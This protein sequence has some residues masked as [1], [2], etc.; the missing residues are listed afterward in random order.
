L[1]R[2]SRIRM[3]LAALQGLFR[4]PSLRTCRCRARRVR[5]R[6]ECRLRQQQ[7]NTPNV[8]FDACFQTTVEHIPPHPY[9]RARTLVLARSH[10][11]PVNVRRPF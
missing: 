8:Q 11:R 1:R 10:H 2:P 6:A 3:C 9:P 4:V 7:I 5:F